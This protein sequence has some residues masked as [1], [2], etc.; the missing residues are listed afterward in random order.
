MVVITWLK[1]IKD[2][3]EAINLD[4][5]YVPIDNSKQLKMYVLLRDLKEK[6]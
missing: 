4:Y 2:I 6:Q 1:E 5:V 3:R